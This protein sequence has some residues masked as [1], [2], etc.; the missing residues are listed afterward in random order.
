[1]EFEESMGRQ[2]VSRSSW[3]FQI[4][5]FVRVFLVG[6]VFVV[7]GVQLRSMFGF[8]C[9]QVLRIK[10]IRVGCCG[11]YRVSSQFLFIVV[12]LFF[13]I[14]RLR[15]CSSVFCRNGGICKE[16]GG[17]YYCSCFFRFIGRY[18]EIGAVFSQRQLV[19]MGGVGF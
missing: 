14:V 3:G 6:S 13:Y 4:V 9:F 7:V 18:C 8:G 1:M 11:C 10:K 17:E 16:V 2:R 19:W 5:S 12:F 15:L